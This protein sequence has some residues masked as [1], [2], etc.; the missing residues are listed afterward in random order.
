MLPWRGTYTGRL[1][2]ALEEPLGRD[3]ELEQAAEPVPLV[4]GVQQ[5]EHLAQD[6]GSSG[7]EGRVESLE[8]ALHRRIQRPGILRDGGE[9]RWW[10]RVP[11]AGTPLRLTRGLCPPSHTELCHSRGPGTP[12]PALLLSS[13]APN[14]PGLETEGNRE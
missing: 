5:P 12:T 3:E 6:S 8:S 1:P 2:Q 14:L 9:C 7:F 4:A 13:G 11:A 10:Q